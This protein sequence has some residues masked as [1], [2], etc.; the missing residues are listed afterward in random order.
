M[1]QR[2]IESRIRSVLWE[3]F[4]P[5]DTEEETCEGIVSYLIEKRE[6]KRP[7]PYRIS[8]PIDDQF[9]ITIEW[10]FLDKRFSNW[11]RLISKVTYRRY[12]EEMS[13]IMKGVFGDATQVLAPVQ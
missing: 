1:T 8:S 5:K 4:R 6:A 10:I 2:E 12:S 13:E 9:D 7:F 3:N 11:N